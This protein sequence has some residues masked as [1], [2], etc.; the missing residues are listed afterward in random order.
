MKAI[1]KRIERKYFI[2][3]KDTLIITAKDNTQRL[4]KAGEDVI[5]TEDDG[6]QYSM[7]RTTFNK[8]YDI[9]DT[10]FCI[11]KANEIDFVLNKTD[12]NIVFP[13]SWGEQ[14]TAFPGAAVVLENGTFGYAIQ[15]KEFEETYDIQ[16]EKIQFDIFGNTH[17][18]KKINESLKTSKQF[19]IEKLPLKNRFEFE[20]YDEAIKC[21]VTW[22]AINK[23]KE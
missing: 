19:R 1:K 2:P 20:I 6:S 9:I 14:I 10:E 15:A 12:K 21:D 8:K 13:A 5:I 7:S 22:I 11:S 4:A 16:D 17:L 3:T 18:V 23:N